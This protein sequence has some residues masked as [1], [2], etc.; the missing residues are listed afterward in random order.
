MSRKTKPIRK[1]KAEITHQSTTCIKP[2]HEQTNLDPTKS[3]KKLTTN[4]Y[5]Y[6]KHINT[7]QNIEACANAG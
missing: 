5:V 2:K 3:P 4:N 7:I 6:H 1:E